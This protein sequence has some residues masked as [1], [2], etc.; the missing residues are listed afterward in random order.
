MTGIV[1][2]AEKELKRMEKTQKLLDE[3]WS[4]IDRQANGIDLDYFFLSDVEMENPKW[5]WPGRIP[6]GNITLIAGHP[7]LGKSQL[8]CSLASVVTCGG[9]W[10]VDRSECDAGSVII[11]SAEDNPRYALGPR[12]EA[13]GAHR[14][15][16]VVLKAS[17]DHDSHGQAISRSWDVSA[18][19]RRLEGLVKRLDSVRLIIIDP[20]SAYLGVLNASKNSQI[21]GALVPLVDMADETDVAVVLVSHLNKSQGQEALMRV[22]DSIAFTAAARACYLVCADDDDEEKRLFLQMKSNLEK[23]M[24]GLAYRIV[25]Q[26]VGEGIHTSRLSWEADAVS[27]TANQAMSPSQEKS[28][29]QEAVDWLGGLMEDGPMLASEVSK[30]ARIEGYSMPTVRRAM[31]SLGIRSRKRF[32]DGKWEWHPAAT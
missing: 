18:D 15:R 22:M 16:I 28:E 30:Q 5:L 11:L 27:T 8:T 24:P 4:D 26:E 9:L 14:D 3:S 21:R 25:S 13:A 29:L 12:M 19:V 10:P 20:I 2:R 6:R 32:V 7:G 31:R 1:E 23:P 17:I